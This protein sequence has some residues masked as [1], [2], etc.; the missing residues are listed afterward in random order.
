MQLDGAWQ[1][2]DV[3]ADLVEFT[4]F[5]DVCKGLA[6]PAVCDCG[7]ETQWTFLVTWL[8][9]V[10]SSFLLLMLDGLVLHIVVV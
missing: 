3:D 10:G 6:P 8:C 5:F 2:L 7:E 1:S 9:G 4:I